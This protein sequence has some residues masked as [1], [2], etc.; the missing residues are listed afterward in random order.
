MN[1]RSV[2]RW[3]LI[4]VGVL[5]LAGVATVYVVTSRLEGWLRDF[6]I[7]TLERELD[8]DVELGKLDIQ[9]GYVTRLS[10]GPLVIRHHRRQDVAPLVQLERFE[11]SMGW[12]EMF[13]RPRRVEEIILTGLDIAI[14]PSPGE[15]QPRFP[16]M[17]PSKPPE[18]PKEDKPPAVIIGKLTADAATLTI[19]PRDTRKLPRRFVL[20]AL[21]VS[22]ISTD[23]PMAFTAVVVNPQP[24]G[25][26][27]TQGTFG[28]WN[29]PTPGQSPLEADYRF[30]DADLS[31]IPGIAGIIQSTGHYSGVIERIQAD[32]TSTTEDFSLDVGGRPLPLKTKFTVIVDG[33]NGDTLIQ[34]AEAVLGAGTPMKVTGGVVKAED[35][36]GRHVDFDV[37][38]ENG[39]LE[40]ILALVIDGTPALRAQLKLN[41]ALRIPPGKVPVVKKMTLDGRF[42]L[43]RTTF[44]S[45]AVQAKIDE[46]S[47][48]AQGRPGDRDVSRVVSNFSGRFTMAD[49]VV[50]FPSLV[51]TVDGARVQLSGH[52]VVHGQGLNFDGIVRLDAGISQM[53]GGKKGA[54][55]KPFNWM[56]R[57]DGATQVPIHIRGTVK[58]PEFGVDVKE[59]LK[60]VFKR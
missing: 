34:P 23:R 4:V 36:S 51:F 47:R 55:L 25:R 8:S 20:E 45:R 49:G 16:D 41:A 37:Q 27:E 40:D 10:G 5:M 24:R 12:R 19:L 60:G 6:V 14:P 35:K 58:N 48:R 33:T 3:A 30:I 17:G 38:I 11:T 31:T 54:L 32:G 13:R 57:Q 29:G 7:A 50:R 26:I 21:T 15:G 39:R 18:P 22:E 53:V 59:T 52:Y 28:P 56:L 42:T 1:R 46:L 2:L 9:L 43:R 44:S